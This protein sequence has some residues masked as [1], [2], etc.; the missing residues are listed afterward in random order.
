MKKYLFT[1]IPLLASFQLY[2]QFKNAGF[3]QS[4]DT[5]KSLPQLWHIKK[6]AGYNFLL[7]DKEKHNGAY[8]L[9][10]Q[11]NSNPVNFSPF[12]QFVAVSTNHIKKIIISAWIK[13]NN[14]RNTP[15]LWCQVRDRTNK[16]IGFNSLQVSGVTDTGTHGWKKYNIT[17]LID[18]NAKGLVAGGFLMGEG[19]LWF[20]DM[21]ITDAPTNIPPSKDVLNLVNEFTN[22]IK[23]NSIY[24]DSLKWTKMQPNID[25]LEQGIENTNDAR[26]VL[27]YIITQLRAVGD[28]H[29]FYQPKIMA[30][31]YAKGNIDPGRPSAKLLSNGIGYVS[32]PAFGSINDTACLNFA[33]KIQELIREL[34]SANNVKGW[35]VDLRQNGGGN[36][37][38]MIA[39][40]GPLIGNHPLGYFVN[41]ANPKYSSD[42]TYRNGRCGAVKVKKPY[43]IKSPKAKVAVLV[44]PHTASSGEMTAISFIDNANVKL[45]G[46]PTAGFTTANQSFRLSNGAFLYLATSY[47]ADKRFK[48]YKGKITPDV[49]VDKPTNGNT[50][51]TIDT[52]STWILE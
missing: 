35:I 18:T 16:M 9:K 51:A 50:D 23:H 25:I 24:R 41:P 17:L 40:L 43:I 4:M 39:G 21:E 12:S 6:V 26:P 3:E 29:S 37:Y 47:T 20:D 49:L 2:A 1:L 7:D 34:D 30:D 10:I 31:N 38:P 19:T 42:W 14:A 11:N 44:G 28:N 22:I 5:A 48:I 52:A 46:Q 27:D 15:G 36:M 45:F 13:S 33:T 8:S 32:V